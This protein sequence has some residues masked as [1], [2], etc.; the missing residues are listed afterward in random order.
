MLAVMLPVLT[1]V[2]GTA[3]IHPTGAVGVNVNVSALAG[4]V[5]MAPDAGC[6]PPQGMA[7]PCRG[8][9]KLW[10]L[11]GA[12]ATATPGPTA[13][14]TWSPSDMLVATRT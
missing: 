3:K 11:A 1:F 2:A 5:V 7:L 13:A 4:N 12:V 6:A 8:T 14:D 9:G 10:L